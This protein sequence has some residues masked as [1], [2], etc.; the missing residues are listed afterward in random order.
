MTS[1]DASLKKIVIFGAGGFARLAHVYFRQDSSFETVAF[2]VHQKYLRET[3]L[4]GLQVVPFEQLEACFPPEQYA[5]FVAIGYERLNQARAGVYA[6]CKARG[7]EL[8]TYISSKAMHCGEIEVGENSF[9]YE[10]NVIH[11]FVKIGKD[12]IIGSANHIGHDSI[13]GDHCFLAGHV[14]I[15]G[16]VK[17]GDYCFIGA[18]ATLKDGITIAPGCVIGG[19]AMIMNDTLPS[20]VYIAERT[21]PCPAASAVLGELMHSPFFRE[22]NSA[23]H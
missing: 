15:P 19:G 3:H 18:N 1:P 21:R 14:M 7:Y 5:M 20:E 6:E 4:L 2:T 11:P 13:I 10:G 12:T 23:S 22:G 8:V 16:F 17:I 9:I